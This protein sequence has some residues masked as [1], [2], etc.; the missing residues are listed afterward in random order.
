[1]T[2]KYISLLDEAALK[3]DHVDMSMLNVLLT[4]DFVGEVAFG[5]NLHTLDEGPNCRILQLFDI[6][7]P[8]LMKCGL[9]PLRA[10]V[11]VL[12]STRN[13][14]K[15]CAELRGKAQEAIKNARAD[16]KL[17]QNDTKIKRIYELLAQ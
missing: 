11:P 17:G 8:E 13:M 1:M 15:A 12:K 10:K 3:N 5:T 6:I 9:F 14:H 7:L 4:L 2:Q 16:D